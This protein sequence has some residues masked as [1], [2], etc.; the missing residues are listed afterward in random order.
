ML[1]FCR[2][3]VVTLTFFAFSSAAP[4]QQITWAVNIIDSAGTSSAYYPAITANLQAAGARIGQFL[5]PATNVTVRTDVVISTAY[6]LGGGTSTTSSYLGTHNGSTLWEQ[7]AAH[8][9]R[10]GVNP[11][12]PN[13]ANIRIDLNPN[14]VANNIWWDPTPT[15]RTSPVPN[16]R[17]DSVSVMMHELTH[18][19]VFNGFRDWTTTAINN[20][21]LSTFDRYVTFDNATQTPF[22]NGP[23]AMALYGG[24]VPLTY[25]NLY[26]VGNNSP[27]AGSELIPDMMNGVVYQFGQR[28]DL[29]A[30]D[31]AIFN[32]SGLPMS[33]VP[34]PTTILLPAVALLIVGVWWRRRLAS[35]TPEPVLA[36]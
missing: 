28:Y 34:E 35:Q 3:L 33:P 14:Y 19:L 18:A 11:N 25:G 23:L 10:T 2:C 4:A 30:L 29:S 13:T 27:R 16:N 1:R 5:S 17:T 26:H 15:L 36:A 7:G 21:S 20:N 9:I 8:L 6:P 31:A 24:P 12:A 32:D 22:F